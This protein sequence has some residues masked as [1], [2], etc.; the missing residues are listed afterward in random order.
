MI[1]CGVKSNATEENF[2]KKS[3]VIAVSLAIFAAVLNNLGVN[4]QKLAWTRKQ[5]NQ[6]KQWNYRMVWIVGMIFVVLASVLDFVALAFGPQSVIA[7]LGSL[8]M[9]CNAFV[10]PRMHGEKLHP[11]VLLSTLVIVVGCALSVANASHSNDVCSVETLFALYWTQRFMVYLIVLVVLIGSTSIFINNAELL[12][13]TKGSDSEEYK[14]IFRYHRVSYAFLAG[15]FGAQSVLF[16]RSI[17]ILLVGT[18]R[19]GR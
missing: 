1:E 5:S 18:T 4:L 7:P 6:I 11:Q 15:L 16:A 8:T 12:I 13:R 3:W 14:K 19:G 10:A 17:D 9:V 2:D